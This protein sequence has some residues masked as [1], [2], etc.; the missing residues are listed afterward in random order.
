MSRIKRETREDM[1]VEEARRVL[2]SENDDSTLKLALR[3]LDGEINRLF[4][5]SVQEP[6][7]L[8]SKERFKQADELEQ[9]AANIISARCNL[10][11]APLKRKASEAFAEIDLFLKK[12]TTK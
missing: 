10:V 12:Y 4:E 11:Q 3:V 5:V 9:I 1:T 6:R 2:D 7:S 8:E